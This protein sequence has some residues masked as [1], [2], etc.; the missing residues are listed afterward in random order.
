[1][2]LRGFE[3]QSRGSQA[4]YSGE[5]VPEDHSAIERVCHKTL[6]PGHYEG[7]EVSTN[8]ALGRPIAIGTSIVHEKMDNIFQTV[9]ALL[10]KPGQLIIDVMSMSN[11]SHTLRV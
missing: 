3:W 2:R 6:I 10:F 4:R 7:P 9:L 5:S 8:F 1:M 11:Q